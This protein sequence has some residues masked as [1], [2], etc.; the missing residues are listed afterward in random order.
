MVETGFMET[1]GRASMENPSMSACATAPLTQSRIRE[2]FR[3]RTGRGRGQY[4]HDTAHYLI[5]II[6]ERCDFEDVGSLIAFCEDPDNLRPWL[7]TEADR[8]IFSEG[9]VQGLR[10]IT[11][12]TLWETARRAKN[13]PFGPLS[14]SV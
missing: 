7:P 2:H 1:K 13:E 8:I 10:E 6:L 11:S 5:E 9:L 12:A 3:H 4:L 14:P